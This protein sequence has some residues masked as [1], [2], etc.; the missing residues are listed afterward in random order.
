MTSTGST[1]DAI[2][3][4]SFGGPEGLEDV[5]PFLENVVRGRGVPKERLEAV[6]EHYVKFDGISPINEQNRRLVAALRDELASRGIH[7]PIYWGNR[8]WH[9]FL[10]D[11]IAQLEAHGH[12][13]I[14][15]VFTSAY[16][17]YSGCRQYREELA[18]AVSENGCQSSTKID[19][20]RPYFDSPGFVLP[21]V[22]GIAD[23]S[24]QLRTEDQSLSAPKVLFTTHSIPTSMSESSGPPDMAGVAGGAY[25]AQHLAVARLIVE[26]VVERGTDIASWE[27][28]YQ[29][30]SGPPQIPWL[31]PDINDAIRRARGEGF[32]SV[33][34]APIGFVSDH[35]EVVWDLDNEALTTCAQL[36]VRVRRVAT[37]GVDPRF[38]QSLGDLVVEKMGG[39]PATALSSLGPWPSPCLP[40]CCPNPRERRGHVAGHDSTF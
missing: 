10:N 27:L 13:S 21:F 30:R 11:V 15:A 29:S 32:T 28:V 18:N 25:V 2:L 20:I 39:P 14:L 4:V 33:I 38:V 24:N 1:Y 26:Q 5:M 37:P 22:D 19:K 31:E 16:S 7:T 36:G 9:P 34:I 23:A 40:G 12:R 17:S 3:L 8:H 35:M 6:A